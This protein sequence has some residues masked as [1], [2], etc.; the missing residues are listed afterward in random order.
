MCVLFGKINS[1][2]ANCEEAATVLPVIWSFYS[3]LI[4]LLVFSLQSECFDECLNDRTVF[5]WKSGSF[6]W[7]ASTP[8]ITRHAFRFVPIPACH[9]FNG[10]DSLIRLHFVHHVDVFMGAPCDQGRL[11]QPFI[12]QAITDEFRFLVELGILSECRHICRK[13]VDL[14][15]RYWK[16]PYRGFS[17]FL[18]CFLIFYSWTS[19]R[20]QRW[21]I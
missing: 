10:L 6:D 1:K 5:Q 13:Q 9:N 11:M 19:R 17:I 15:Q 12:E 2:E 7:N 18:N 21:A 8:V 14:L 16:T 4:R 3:L 20:W